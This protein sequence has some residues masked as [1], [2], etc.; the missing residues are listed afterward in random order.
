M[1]DDGAHGDGAA[2]D[3]LFGAATTNYPAASKVRFYVEARSANPAKAAAFSP[4]RAE[5]ETYSYRVT[6]TTASNTPVVINELLSDNTTILV[7]PQGQYDDWIELRNFTE[8]PANL[9]SVSMDAQ[10]HIILCES[11]YC[12]I[13]RIRFERLAP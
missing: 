9:R 4:A 7:D 3:G 1:Y 13:R 11:D 12:Y 6:L 5:Q 2:G 10:G 8:A